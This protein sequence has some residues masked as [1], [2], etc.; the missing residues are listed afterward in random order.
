MS[1]RTGTKEEVAD[2]PSV[3][4]FTTVFPNQVQPRLGVFVRERM[5]RV[6]RKLPLVVVAPVAWFPFQGLIRL[7]RPGFRPLPPSREIDDGIEIL[8]PRFLSVPG[9]FKWL[10]GFSMAVC[11]LPTLL[12]L[13]REYPLSVI[14]SHFAYPDGYAANFLGGWL[15]L[16][17]TITLRG[18]ESS[19]SRFPLRRRLILAAVRRADRVFSVADSLASHLRDLGATKDILRIGNGV[20]SGRFFP[21]DRKTARQ[22]FAIAPDAKVLVSVG[23]LCERKGFHR[24]IGVLP[25]LLKRF[26]GL[27]LLIVGG[28]S[29]EGD[30]SQR[31]ESQIRELGLEDS[32]RFLG[33]MDPNDLRWPLS[34]ADVFV[35]AT[36]NEGWANVFLEAMACGLPV[37]TTDVGGNAEVIADRNLGTLVPFGDSNALANAL[38]DALLKDWNREEIRDWAAANSW[39]QRIRILVREFSA[40]SAGRHSSGGG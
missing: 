22:R 17:V 23:G 39:D 12:R 8:H 9:L 6:A 31:L 4:V 21:E 36:R 24:V 28:A 5:F 33:T 7:W 35:L 34:A 38:A 32:V 18:T 15:G 40:V 19:L 14:D 10:D 29:P 37:V 16:P 26:P 1:R 27:V 3:L 25:R 20:D 13:R 11:S 2:R 30:W